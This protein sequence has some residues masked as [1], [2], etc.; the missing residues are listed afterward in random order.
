MD[1]ISKIVQTV[2]G[3]MSVGQSLEQ[4]ILC[5]WEQIISGEEKKHAKINKIHE[6]ILEITIDTSAW[7]Y[8]FNLKR[9]NI[10][11]QLQN[12]IPEI[13]NIYFKLGTTK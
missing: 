13:K 12:E 2:I 6:G 4:C 3:R 7:L 5:F 1:N 9:N 10:L 8:Q 11:K